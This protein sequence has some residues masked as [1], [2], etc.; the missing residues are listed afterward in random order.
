MPRLKCD[1][2][3]NFGHAV[4]SCIKAKIQEKL[5]NSSVHFDNVY[6][7]EEKYSAVTAKT[8]ADMAPRHP[9]AKVIPAAAS[10]KK[11]EADNVKNRR[12]HRAP[13]EVK[14]EMASLRKEDREAEKAEKFSPTSTLPT[15]CGDRDEAEAENEPSLH[16]DEQNQGRNGHSSLQESRGRPS[17]ERYGGI[18]NSTRS[19]CPRGNKSGEETRGDPTAR[20]IKRR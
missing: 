1:E 2:M 3:F 10:R 17:E 6:E 14:A 7:E 18:G 9:S 19:S 4:V 16:R 5:D 8:T 11:M 15:P 20:S 13:V 12:A